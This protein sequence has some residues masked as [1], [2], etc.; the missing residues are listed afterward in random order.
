MMTLPIVWILLPL[1][2]GFCIYLLPALSRWLGLGVAVV[3]SVY[4]LNLILQQT[5][6]TLELIDHFGVT[7]LLNAQ[8][9]FFILTNGLVTAAVIL[10]C[11]RSN[12]SAFF[13]TQLSIL[14]GSINAVFIC[15]DF[16]SLYVALEAI[17]ITVF[18][19]IAYPRT[20]RTIWIALRYL[21]V[22]NT[23]M[24]FYL[25]GAVLVYQANHS[26]AFSGLNQAPP[27]AVA[28]ILLG[29]LTKGGVFISGLWLPLTHAEAEAP[30][31]AL[32]SGV[33]IKA[34]IF[35]LLRCT[36]LVDSVDIVIRI[37]GMGTT[38]M[39]VSFAMLEKDVKRI[40]ALSTISQM[41]FVLAAPQVGGLYALSHGL[42]K[43]TL[44]L[45]TGSLPSRNID[46]LRQKPMPRQVW[47]ALAIA[48]LSISGLPLLVGFGA[49][50]LTLQSLLPWQ[51]I[52]MNVAAVGTAIV[53]SKLLCLPHQPESEKPIA[54]GL[55]PAALLLISGLVIANGFSLP[56][57]SPS[58]VIKA[59]VIIA[60]GWT[61]YFLILRKVPLQVPRAIEQV[62]QLIGMMSLVLLGLFWL[63]LV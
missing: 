28:L 59:L 10:Y 14:H 7:L 11:W 58:N 27:E 61:A 62:E 42:A 18:L 4:G 56:S 48:G 51:I 2:A 60:V 5:P 53:F 6:F 19:L 32:L 63:V 36:E 45:S 33:A 40:F 47:F 22:S 29:L 49:K 16:I 3:S 26:F 20:D 24:L 43:A 52:P 12:R 55:R 41:G 57:Y 50:V 44:F 35:P 21:F 15:A 31:S 34:G 1:V 30:I 13:Y 23:A 9:G 38:V 46:Q 37:F 17:S 54:V 25:L 39:G 8:S